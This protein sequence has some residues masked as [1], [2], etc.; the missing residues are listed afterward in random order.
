MCF[1]HGVDI[2]T[3]GEKQ[4]I[5]KLLAG[6][7]G[8]KA[9]LPK[10]TS[11][12]CILPHRHSKNMLASL[13]TVLDEAVKIIIRFCPIF[14]VFLM[15]RMKWEAHTKHFC[16][17]KCDWCLS[18]GKVLVGLFKLRNEI[19]FFF[20][21]NTIFIWRSNWQACWLIRLGVW[22]IFSWKWRKWTSCF[23]EN[24]YLLLIENL[25]FQVEVRIIE[26]FLCTCALFWWNCGDV[27]KGFASV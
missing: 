14:W 15:F 12:H 8:I 25:S 13:N 20:L 11:G 6:T 18:W 21:W 23:K 4:L 1:F 24:K 3:Y 22:Q 16:L 10:C 26:N 5:G 19:G 27:K 9:V 7:I 17:P 2:C